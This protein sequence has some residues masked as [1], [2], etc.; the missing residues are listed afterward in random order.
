[1]KKWETWCNEL[2]KSSEITAPRCVYP[3]ENVLE[4]TLHGFGDASKK[5]YCAVVYFVYRTDAGIYARLLT[6]KARVAPLK[7][8]SIPRLELMSARLLA[9]LMQTVRVI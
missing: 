4:C 7:Q 8:T 1:M 5:A 2:I 9:Q 6:S 3:I